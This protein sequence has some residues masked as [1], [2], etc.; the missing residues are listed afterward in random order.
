MRGIAKRH[1]ARPVRPL[2]A[3]IDFFDSLISPRSRAR[4]RRD[5][6]AAVGAAF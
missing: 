5:A 4:R 1:I 3:A 6:D 2:A